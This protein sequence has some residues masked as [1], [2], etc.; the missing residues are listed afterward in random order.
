MGVTWKIVKRAILSQMK[1]ARWQNPNYIALPATW[2]NQNRWMDNEFTTGS[3]ERKQNVIG[4][5]DTEFKYREPDVE[6]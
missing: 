1:S 2:I 3:F 5:Q 4:Y 6:M